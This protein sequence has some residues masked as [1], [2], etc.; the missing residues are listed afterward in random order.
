MAFK[1]FS[2]GVSLT[3]VTIKL[4]IPPLEVEEIYSDFLRLG[5]KSAIVKH[6]AELR[7]YILNFGNL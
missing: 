2:E 6:F 1:L 4:D 5:G 7:G 3:D